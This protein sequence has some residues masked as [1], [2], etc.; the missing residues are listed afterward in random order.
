MASAVSRTGARA[1]TGEP[2]EADRED[3]SVV[4]LARG[5]SVLRA[6]RSSHAPLSNKEIAE[7]T[8]LPK[9]TVARLCYT[10]VRTGYL[11]QPEPNGSYRLG[12]KV[13]TIGEAFLGSLPV[14]NVARGLMQSFA[15]GHDV[16]V[17]L[18]MRERNSMAYIEYCSG[19]DTVTMRLRTGSMIPIALTAMGRAYL[20]A[21]PP[22]ERARELRHA[23]EELDEDRSQ[24][25]DGTQRSFEELDREGFCVSLG[26]WRPQVFGVAA[27][28][29]L[30]GGRVVLALNAGATRQAISERRL[31]DEVG[32]DLVRLST[33]IAN[34]MDAARQSFWG[35]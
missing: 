31:R 13:A 12:A 25:L 2:A 19:P 35:E 11:R 10:L 1:E 8:G 28:V 5:L 21:L 33:E 24:V 30:D 9:P 16:S 15:D 22:E 17:A 29:W 26:T 23:M 14:R 4:S 27:P 32:P 20:W 6:F 7:R 18:G 3:G 34:G